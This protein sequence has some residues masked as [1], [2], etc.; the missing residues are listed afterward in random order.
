MFVFGLVGF[1]VFWMFSGL[2]LVCGVD[3]GFSFWWVI[4]VIRLWV[5]WVAVIKRILFCF[6]IMI[7]D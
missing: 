1:W 6:V 2:L 5:C 3:C 4:C 7:G